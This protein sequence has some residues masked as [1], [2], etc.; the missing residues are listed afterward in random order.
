MW[1]LLLHSTWKNYNI[2]FMYY[3]ENYSRNKITYWYDKIKISEK[4]IIEESQIDTNML[5]FS[6]YNQ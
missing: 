1:T 6:T 5:E 3:Q 4:V 2:V